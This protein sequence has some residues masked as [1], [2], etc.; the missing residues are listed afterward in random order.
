MV[1]TRPYTRNKIYSGK[2]LACF[3]VALLLLL[4]SFVASFAVGIAMFGFTAKQVLVVVNASN[5][6]LISPFLVMLIYFGSLLLN[7]VFYISLALIISM[8]IKQT[9]ISTSITSAVF[10]ISTVI[11]GISNSS[12]LRFVPSLN[13]GIFKF[14]T[15]SKLG[16]FSYNV[17]PNI[18][19]SYCLI[20][21]AVSV[22]VFDILG[23]LLFT[24]RSIDK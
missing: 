9:V 4:L 15:Q 14:F 1:A 18:T 5:V 3:N 7:I 20:M 19:M 12:S 2:S 21:I 8:L 16:I 24:H 11:Q 23:R 22:L 6:I 10:I 17:I 13:L